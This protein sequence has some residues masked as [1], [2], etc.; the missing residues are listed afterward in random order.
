M[1]RLD[2]RPV[3]VVPPVTEFAPYITQVN[4]LLERLTVEI[5]RRAQ[6]P[7]PV[8]PTPVA[9][10][11]AQPIAAPTPVVPP[12]QRTILQYLVPRG[13][14]DNLKEVTRTS[15]GEFCWPE[16]FDMTT[17][18]TPPSEFATP[19]EQSPETVG[20]GSADE[21][22]TEPTWPRGATSDI[23]SR[24]N[25]YKFIRIADLEKLDRNERR[26]YEQTTTA[27]AVRNEGGSDTQGLSEQSWD[28]TLPKEFDTAKL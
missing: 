23:L 19:G 27:C 20:E 17:T 21:A 1:E 28:V 22:D 11:I 14:L 15:P 16:E 13:P 5:I 4:S 12:N 18:D 24:M 9:V 2:Q 7:A 26:R 3:P 25:T 6:R 10:P 8:V